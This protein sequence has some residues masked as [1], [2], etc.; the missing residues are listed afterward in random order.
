LTDLPH[1]TR[2]ALVTLIDRWTT[3]HPVD[4]PALKRGAPDYDPEARA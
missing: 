1:S 3:L 4:D 2:R